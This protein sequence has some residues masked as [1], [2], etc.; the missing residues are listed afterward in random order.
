MKGIMRPTEVT[1]VLGRPGA[2]C[3]TFLKAIAAQ[4]YGFQ[5]D[6]NSIISYNGLTPKDIT[7]HFR[8]GVIY[9][10]ENE[11]HFPHLTVG[12]TL[13]FATKLRTPQNRPE[14]VSRED[15]MDHMTKVVMAMYG[16]SH[17]K[18]T[19]VGNDFIRGVS[20]GE[21]KR[22]SI[23]EV[24]LSFASLQCWETPLEGKFRHRI[25]IYQSIEGIRH[26]FGRYSI[27][28]DLSMFARRLQL[29]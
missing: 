13:E 4:T 20:G 1:V 8:G 10:A 3:S 11:A 7:N 2:G 17:T 26:C 19:K 18:N 5:V 14:G 27:D 16:L 24:A 22:V 25:R 12:D 9:C 6:P 21:R 29:V 15:Y 23:A 28:C